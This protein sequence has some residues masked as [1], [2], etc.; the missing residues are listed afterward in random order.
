MTAMLLCDL[1][2]TLLGRRTPERNKERKGARESAR[3]RDSARERAVSGYN[4]HNAE[5]PWVPLCLRVVCKCR[6]AIQGMKESFN[7]SHHS[8]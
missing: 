1:P 4:V 8:R 5:C 7:H 6:T 3:A 2:R